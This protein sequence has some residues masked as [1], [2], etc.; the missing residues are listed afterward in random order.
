MNG[1]PKRL[2]L[3]AAHLRLAA[4]RGVKLVLTTDAHS[5]DSLAHLEWSV[6]T[7]RRGWVER[8]MV[9]NCLP[10]GGFVGALGKRA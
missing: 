6:A 8:G 5:V 3:N 4:K 10:A 7:A 9:L 2:D 1:N